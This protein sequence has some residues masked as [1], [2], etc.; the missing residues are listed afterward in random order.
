[1]RLL[2]WQAHGLF[3]KIGTFPQTTY[4]GITRIRFKG[5]CLQQISASRRPCFHVR[6][7]YSRSASKVKPPRQHIGPA[8]HIFWNKHILAGGSS[9][10]R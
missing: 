4:A 1:M 6:F 8:G 9:H 2:F 3:V 10:E 7:Q 5:L